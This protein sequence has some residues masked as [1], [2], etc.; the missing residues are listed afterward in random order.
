MIATEEEIN[1]VLEEISKNEGI[2]IRNLSLSLNMHKQKLY[3]IVGVLLER[4]KIS[5][6]KVGNS[7]AIFPVGNQK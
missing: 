1:K 3:F 6:K 7:Y 5:L 4:K 2:T